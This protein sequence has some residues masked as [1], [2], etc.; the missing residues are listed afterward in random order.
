LHAL[1]EAES[2]EVLT[3]LDPVKES[4]TTT[5]SDTPQASAPVD[6]PHMTLA[7]RGLCARDDDDTA[8]AME[9]E[10]MRQG[11]EGEQS[12][13]VGGGAGHHTA[14]DNQNIRGNIIWRLRPVDPHIPGHSARQIFHIWI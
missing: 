6:T 1:S 10:I 11:D 5:I 7:N 14:G 2:Q 3:L 9:G 8:G 4:S 13:M 12:R